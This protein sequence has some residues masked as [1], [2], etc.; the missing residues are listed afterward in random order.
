MDALVHQYLLDRDQVH[1]QE[2]DQCE[3]QH[4]GQQDDHPLVDDQHLAP[5][6]DDQ[7]VAELDDCYLEAAEL[8]DQMDPYAVAGAVQLALLEQTV[9]LQPQEFVQLLEQLLLAALELAQHWGRLATGATLVTGRAEVIGDEL[10]TGRAE[11][12]GAACDSTTGRSVATTSVSTVN[13]VSCISLLCCSLLCRSFLRNCFL[14][15]LLHWFCVATFFGGFFGAAFF[16]AFF[17]GFGSSGC[18]SRTR[19]SRSAR[20]NAVGL[21]L[22]DR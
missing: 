15:C 5:H 8:D 14:R 2:Y 7:V 12:I 3:H 18:C 11:V 17:T 21:L 19:P 20:A 4:P 1:L 16:A 13:F 6:P 9:Q 22:D 10:V